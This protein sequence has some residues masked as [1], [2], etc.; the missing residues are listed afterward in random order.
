VM[1]QIGFWFMDVPVLLYLSR[2]SG[3]IFDLR[4]GYAS[5]C[6]LDDTRV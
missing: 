2:R 6:T 4:L 1:R 5:A 3:V